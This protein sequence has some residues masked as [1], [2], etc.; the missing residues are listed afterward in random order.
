MPCCDECSDDWRVDACRLRG[1]PRAAR[2][3]STA[4]RARRFCG[5]AVGPA[6]IAVR[7]CAD[8]R[9]ED[10]DQVRM[11]A[12]VKRKSSLRQVRFNLREDPPHKHALIK[13]P[14][15][16]FDAGVD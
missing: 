2:D 12:E 14:N 1:R 6:C 7:A 8:G 16:W 13:R 15:E 10:Q 11:M 3:N 5:A 9:D 4:S